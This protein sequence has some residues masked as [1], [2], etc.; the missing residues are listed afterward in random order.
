[1]IDHNKVQQIL[2]LRQQGLSL[3]Q[4]QL[5][6]QC[7]MLTI[8][9][10]IDNPLRGLQ[11]Q[12]IATRTSKLDTFDPQRLTDLFNQTRGNFVVIA[13][14]LARLAHQ[15]G[16]SDFSIDASSVRRY[17]QKKFPE[18]SQP[19]SLE[20]NSF[21]VEPGQ[22]LQIDFV[23]ALFT[24]AGQCEPTRLYIF[25]AIY[26]WSRKR[27]VRICHDS[28]QSSWY[29]STLDCLLRYGCPRTILCDNDK[30]L[31]IAHTRNG[32]RFNPGFTWICKPFGI[33]PVACKPRHAKTKG[34]IERTGRYIKENALAEAATFGDIETIEQLQ[35]FLDQWVVSVS[36]KRK[37]WVNNQYQMSQ[38]LYE[39]EK[40]FLHF[41][42]DEKRSA[43]LVNVGTQRV[44]D[45]GIVTLHGW[46][47]NIGYRHKG[48]TVC[49]YLR[50]NG[51]CMVMDMQG[52][53]I[54]SFTVPI[55]YMQNHGINDKPLT[56]TRSEDVENDP[57][58]E[59][60]SSILEF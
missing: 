4:I 1:M 35:T 55:A 27:Y 30:S 16:N 20:I 23:E 39:Q 14:S 15:Q 57:Y 54:V 38:K 33:E 59:Q 24:F 34:R 49:C 60:L 2:R 56:F 46:S 7:S 41:I 3:R 5:A 36:D 48:R 52:K 42:S 32:V 10:Y 45:Q 17:Y 8:R 29:L 47:K 43:A 26:S 53:P 50:P 18:L 31:V 21:D 11:Q 13:R 51:N 28:Q 37:Y 9:R 44:S 22:Q 6:T 40:T 12:T 58:L 19:K 25:E